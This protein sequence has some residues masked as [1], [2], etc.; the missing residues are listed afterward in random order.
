[1][2]LFVTAVDHRDENAVEDEWLLKM[3]EGSARKHRERERERER[4]I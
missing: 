1:M 3:D 2:L 4:K